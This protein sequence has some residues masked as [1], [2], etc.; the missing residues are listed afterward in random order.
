[1]SCCC[2]S[3]TDL[4]KT[5]HSKQ[6]KSAESDAG[7]NPRKNGDHSPVIRDFNSGEFTFVL[8]VS[9]ENTYLNWTIFGV[10][11]VNKPLPLLELSTYHS[12]SEKSRLF[13]VRYQGR[14]SF[15]RT[16][17]SVPFV[18]FEKL[19]LWVNAE[20]IGLVIDCGPETVKPLAQRIAT[21]PESST[22][23]L[24]FNGSG[25]E[26]FQVES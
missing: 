5:I 4:L 16:T 15:Q 2:F 20:S 7:S 22:V 12:S 14:K 17:F 23:S 8:A 1:M 13:M 26:A 6:H 24:G 11:N 18:T 25:G 3:V 19:M 10:Y 21:I 9:E